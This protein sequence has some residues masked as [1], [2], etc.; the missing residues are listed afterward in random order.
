MSVL[1]AYFDKSV[2]QAS[3]IQKDFDRVVNY[4]IDG[5][6]FISYQEVDYPKLAV[7]RGTVDMWSLGSL[8]KAG[9][10]PDMPIHTGF[11]TRLEG[12]NVLQDM[13]SVVDGFLLDDETNKVE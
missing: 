8:L 9:I 13:S 5:N 12:V 6:E 4:D 11:N 10:S 3:P 2:N 1:K 7:A